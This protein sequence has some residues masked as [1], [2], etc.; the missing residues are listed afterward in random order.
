LTSS[1]DTVNEGLPRGIEATCDR[2]GR[3][4]RHPL[5]R[6]KHQQTAIAIAAIYAK[7]AKCSS[8]GAPADVRVY[9]FE[10]RN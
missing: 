1:D 6:V 7:T 9:G 3:S 2:C 5:K 8:C 10:T 4:D